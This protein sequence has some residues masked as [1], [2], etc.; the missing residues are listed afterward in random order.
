VTGNDNTKPNYLAWCAFRRQDQVG[1]AGNR[2]E[3]AR[4]T[5]A[6]GFDTAAG[7][8]TGIRYSVEVSSDARRPDRALAWGSRP[9]LP[10]FPGHTSG[11]NNPA[12]HLSRSP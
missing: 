10:R 11:G 5:A 1:S 2:I 9:K 12:G 3:R 8:S 7:R 4:V 6:G